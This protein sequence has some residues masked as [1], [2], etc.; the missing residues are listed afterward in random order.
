MGS[1]PQRPTCKAR[2]RNEKQIRTWKSKTWP[3]IKKESAR[4]AARSSSST[5]VD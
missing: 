1:S 2:E 4:K 5:N 3:G